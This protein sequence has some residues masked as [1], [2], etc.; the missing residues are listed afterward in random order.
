MT[1]AA[2]QY[3]P[4]DKLSP[5]K[6][7]ARQ[8]GGAK[9]DDLVASIRAEGLLQNLTVTEGKKGKFEVVAGARRLRALQQLAKAG[10]LASNDVPCR[11][12]DAEVAMDA[13]TAENTIREQ[14]HPADE[15]EA[16]ARLHKQGR[17]VDDIAV[18]FGQTKRHVQRMLKLAGLSPAL[19]DTWREGELTLAMAQALAITDDHTKQEQAF[20]LHGDPDWDEDGDAIRAALTEGDLTSRDRITRYI[21]LEAYET[22]GGAVRRDLFAEDE[23]SF[24]LVDREL[25]ERLALEKLQKTADRER[26]KGWL[27]VEVALELPYNKT[28]NL[29]RLY[30]T[31]TPEQR[32]IAGVFVIPGSNG[33]ASI[34]GP[35]IRPADQQRA[36]RGEDP[37]APGDAPPAPTVNDQFTA[38]QTA[39]LLGWRTAILRQTLAGNPDLMVRALVADLAEDLIR[40][41]WDRQVIVNAHIGKAYDGANDRDVTEGL[42]EAE[43]FDINVNEAS[44]AWREKLEAVQGDIL[45]WLLEQPMETVLALLAHIAADGIWSADKHPEREADF[46]RRA[47]FDARAIWGPDAEWLQ[48]LTKPTILRILGHFVSDS[49]LGAFATLK[50]KELAIKAAEVLNGTD[51]VP[52]PLRPAGFIA[53]W[54]DA[55]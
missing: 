19:L 5:S 37:Q 13:S 32:A 16:Y 21:G 33:R 42:R 55:P 39:R 24:S 31:P 52:A 43:E 18:R 46:M 7:N 11:V 23:D 28:T 48:T 1:S 17:S 6:L 34:E 12:V 29:R 53:P 4:L 38:K 26:K 35:Y 20:K 2:I 30:E 41:R 36:D 54:S 49:E 45:G 40:E 50:K 27:W 9:V 47:G 44:A 51:Y 14:M 22:A 15:V 25:A 3:I 8:H 10:E